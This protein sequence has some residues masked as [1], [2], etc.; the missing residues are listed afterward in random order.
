MVHPED[1]KNVNSALGAINEWSHLPFGS[2]KNIQQTLQPSRQAERLRRKRQAKQ[3]QTPSRKERMRQGRLTRAV[4]NAIVVPL[5]LSGLSTS[6]KPR[7]KKP[8][9]E[10]KV[11]RHKELEGLG[12][13]TIQWDGVYVFIPFGFNWLIQSHRASIPIKTPSGT[14]IAVL[15]GRPCGPGWDHHM[16]NLAGDMDAAAN[17]IKSSAKKGHRHGDYPAVNTGVSYGGGSQVW[18]LSLFLI[19]DEKFITDFLLVS[20]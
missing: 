8:Q 11:Y 16:G 6:Q 18:T 5:E 20:C 14:I 13:R 3:D 9:T 19:S 7:P 15:V 17:F 12:I 2:I 10:R 1:S 4:E